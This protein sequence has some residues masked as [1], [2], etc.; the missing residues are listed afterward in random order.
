ML[1]A[2]A[3][4]HGREPLNLDWCFVDEAMVEL[5]DQTPQWAPPP[6]RRAAR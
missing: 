5:P 6:P 3:A 2:E 4:K 1:E